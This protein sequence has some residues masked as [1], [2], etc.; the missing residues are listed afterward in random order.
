MKLREK[1][2][3]FRHRAESG[4]GKS[5]YLNS[6]SRTLSKDL[7]SVAFLPVVRTPKTFSMAS[8][9]RYPGVASTRLSFQEQKPASTS[10]V[11]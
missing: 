8:A 9:G 10:I 1:T 3:V 6:K 7:T 11:P 2:A 4:S 5:A